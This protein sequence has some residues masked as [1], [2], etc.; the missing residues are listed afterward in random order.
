M[1]AQPNATMSVE[2]YLEF[3]RASE[4]KHEYYGGEVLAMA[5]ASYD[6]NTIVGNV[7]ATLRTQLRGKP[8]RV[9]FSDIRVQI[10]DSGLF[11]YPDL[12]VVCG[13]PQ[14]RDE[15]R[16]A[17]LNPKVIIEVLSP[18][19]ESHD[20]GRK[21]QY[22]RTIASLDEYVLITQETP[23]IEHFV[24]QANDLWLFSEAV[25]LNATLPLPTIDCTLALAG[26][27]QEVALPE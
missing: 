21:F 10:P 19:T 25:G 17:L 13:P 16:D 26:V 15:R 1:A 8:C 11:T 22:Y 9:N 24:R 27:Y 18:S 23:R 2:E 3:E 4:T 6:H 14:F 5:G 7:F 12:T 20:R